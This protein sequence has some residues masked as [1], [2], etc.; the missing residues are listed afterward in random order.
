MGLINANQMGAEKEEMIKRGYKLGRNLIYR[1]D[2][3]SAFMKQV[4][5]AQPAAALAEAIV[6]VLEKIQADMKAPFD[7][8]FGIGLMLIAD[9]ADALNE[10]GRFNL[11]EQ[12]ISQAVELGVHQYLQVHGQEFDANELKATYDQQAPMMEGVV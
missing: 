11:T 4:E 12:D 7:V 2:V 10:T 6:F 5:G 8:V 9:L 1:K 3:F